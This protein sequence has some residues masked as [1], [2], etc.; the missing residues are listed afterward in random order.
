MACVSN[1]SAV[2]QLLSIF[3]SWIVMRCCSPAVCLQLRMQCLI[4]IHSRQHSTHLDVTRWLAY[5]LT[6]FPHRTPPIIFTFLKHSRK[7]KIPEHFLMRRYFWKWLGFIRKGLW[8]LFHATSNPC[9]VCNSRTA[10][11]GS[12][13]TAEVRAEGMNRNHG[14]MRVTRQKKKGI[15]GWKRT[16]Q[17]CWCGSKKSRLFSLSSHVIHLSSQGQCVYFANIS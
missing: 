7:V 13:E 8:V 17:L 14:P 12:C 2:Q 10:G 4:P 5:Y 9:C 15:R 6:G 16:G 11:H 3:V 1:T